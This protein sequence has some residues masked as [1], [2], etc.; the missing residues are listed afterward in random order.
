MAEW[1]AGQDPT[2]VWVGKMLGLKRLNRHDVLRSLSLASVSPPAQWLGQNLMRTEISS[3]SHILVFRNSQRQ[4]PGPRVGLAQRTE[5]QLCGQS[6]RTVGLIELPVP[7]H[8][9]SQASHAAKINSSLG[10][11]RRA[12][13]NAV[14][15]AIQ[16]ESVL[17]SGLGLE[18]RR[19]KECS[20][21]PSALAGRKTGHTDTT[22]RGSLV[23]SPSSEFYFL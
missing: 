9:N 18:A 22:G 13:K 14:L 11:V 10:L 21:L 19:L 1:P 16:G 15:R 5:R 23:R 17:Y 12:E 7:R 8:R 2:A 20:G 3:S 6:G 4:T